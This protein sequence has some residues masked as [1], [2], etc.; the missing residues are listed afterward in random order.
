MK[1]SAKQANF[2]LP[3]E[4]LEE[5]RNTIPKRE[6]SKVVAEAVRR[7][8]KRLRLAKAIETSFGIWQDADHP[9][10]TGGTDAFIR[11]VR[12]STRSRRNT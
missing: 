4:L 12:K 8:L 9:E 6:Q 11:E 2:L 1:G 10:L 5:L 3:E 7:E